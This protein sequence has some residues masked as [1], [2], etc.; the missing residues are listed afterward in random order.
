M[1]R[2]IPAAALLPKLRLG[3]YHEIPGTGGA[4]DDAPRQ[5]QIGARGAGHRD[6]HI[7]AGNRGAGNRD[8][9]RRAPGHLAAAPRRA[10]RHFA[11]A[12][13]CPA[14]VQLRIAF[15]IFCKRASHSGFGPARR[16]ALRPANADGPPGPSRRPGTERPPPGLRGRAMIAAYSGMAPQKPPLAAIPDPI[17]SMGGAR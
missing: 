9:P 2:E 14:S 7:L 13:T 8:Q 1:Q 6:Q 17:A 12:A 11:D 10:V 15:G 3:C 5:P 4:G 16:G